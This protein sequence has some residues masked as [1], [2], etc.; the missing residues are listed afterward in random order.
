MSV[1]GFARPPITA[2][3]NRITSD[4]LAQMNDD[5]VLRR[6][7]SAVM[8]RVVAAAV[9][10]LY[11][12]LEY[13]AKNML[14][15]MADEE[16][17]YRHS[18]MKKVERKS[19]RASLGYVRWEG[20]DD[21]LKVPAGVIIQ[22]G[23]RREFITI[24]TVTSSKG[25]LRVRVQAIEPGLDSNSDDG[26]PMTLAS[27]IN[28]LPSTGYADEIYG[29]DDLENLEEWRLRIIDRWYHIPQGGA[30]ADYEIWALEVNGISR[31]WAKRTWRGAGTVG[32]MLATN[33]PDHPTPSPEHIE[34]TRLHILPLAPIAGS[35]LFVFGVDEH[36]IDMDI[37][38]QPDSAEIRAAVIAEV[39]AM[40]YR[41]GVPGGK[42]YPSRIS[43]A[44]SL[45]TGEFTHK[46][47][48]PADDVQLGETELPLLGEITW[49]AL[50]TSAATT[51]P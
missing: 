10:A 21:N 41:D 47:N 49:Q 26:E 44:I 42:I 32:V 31:A 45:A 25:S 23:D 18:A 15:D 48:E 14:P 27:P 12:S 6:M 34:E 4:I 39:K 5:D 1:S 13:L 22:R 20:V 17:L 51:K 43:E 29:G 50:K 2:L 19:P 36:P 28:G 37:T 30:D 38:L 11:G 35:G 8:G 24:E 33:D 46:L 3:I 16:W 9:N 7:D 40:L